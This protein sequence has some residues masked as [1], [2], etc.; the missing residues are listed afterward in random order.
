MAVE[1]GLPG[2]IEVRLGGRAVDV[3]HMR[4]RCVPGALLVDVEADPARV[5]RTRALLG[6]LG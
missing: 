5:A 4:Q 1:F 2:V 6:A 3:G